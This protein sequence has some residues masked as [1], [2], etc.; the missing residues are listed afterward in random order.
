LISAATIQRVSDYGS[1]EV[2]ELMT[3]ERYRCDTWF[4]D[5]RAPNRGWIADAL[6]ACARRAVTGAPK[7]RAMEII[8]E[9]EPTRRDLPA[10]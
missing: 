1:V 3:V 8:D 9:F 5:R 7:V 2:T 10:R 6:A 4:L